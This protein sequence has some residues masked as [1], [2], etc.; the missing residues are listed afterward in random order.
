MIKGWLSHRSELT[1]HITADRTN[2]PISIRLTA[3]LGHRRQNEMCIWVHACV[4]MNAVLVNLNELSAPLENDSIWK[5]SLRRFWSEG[6]RTKRLG[7]GEM[8]RTGRWGEQWQKGSQTKRKKK[9]WDRM[10]SGVAGADRGGTREEREIEKAKMRW[11]E[12]EQERVSMF[13]TSHWF[14][15]SGTL[16]SQELDCSTLPLTDS[17]P[18]V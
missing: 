16:V 18:A 17:W 10:K 4:C 13:E 8:Q 7:G 12:T 11:R 2:H 3:A 9:K 14:L 1:N 5:F 6:E 15:L